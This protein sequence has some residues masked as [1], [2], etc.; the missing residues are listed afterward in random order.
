MPAR[1][2]NMYS[3]NLNGWFMFTV[4]QGYARYIKLENLFR[5]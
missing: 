4:Y 3:F 2:F 5:L 1:D